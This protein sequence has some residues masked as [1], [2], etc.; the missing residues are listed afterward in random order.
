MNSVLLDDL[1]ELY[2]SGN[3]DWSVFDDKT[4]FI[5][6]ATGLIGSL[7]ARILA[8]CSY[9]H[10]IKVNI[11]LNVRNLD[12]ARQ[13]FSKE[14]LD[15]FEF[16]VGDVANVNYS[17][18]HID[19]IIHCANVT[20]SKQMVDYPV[21][22]IM[23]ALMGTINVLNQA[24]TMSVKS[25]VYVSSMEVYGTVLNTD[26]KIDESMLGYIDNLRVRSNYPESKRMCENICI[27]YNHEYKLPVK[28]ARPA[29]TFGAGVLQADNRV[30]AQFVRSVLNNENIVLKT[31]GKSEGNYCYSIDCVEAIFILLLKGI[32]GEAYNITNEENHTT[33]REMAFLV[34]DKIANNRIKVLFDIDENANQMYAPE[35]KLNLSSAKLSSLGWKPR[36]NLIESFKRTIAFKKEEEYERK[37]TNNYGSVL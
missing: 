37:D 5:T 18:K 14:E 15:C 22:T 24:R 9:K 35:T 31:E 12:K 13:L 28:I 11:V 25:I 8:Y 6:G 7:C 27:G 21:E 19:Y 4:V 20:Q 16:V 34:R 3:V 29:Q 32:N 2:K 23:T 17:H 1:K 10:A 26:T 30:Y 36:Y 33:I